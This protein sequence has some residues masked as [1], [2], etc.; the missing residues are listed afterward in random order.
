MKH[1]RTHGIGT[2]GIRTSPT[3]DRKMVQVHVVGDLGA[4][5][6]LGM[7]TP[8]L[9]KMVGVPIDVNDPNTWKAEVRLSKELLKKLK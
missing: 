6:F 4:V 5:E 3:K 1:R 9:L 2:I 8:N 7:F